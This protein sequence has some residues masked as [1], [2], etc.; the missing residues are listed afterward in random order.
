MRGTPPQ[1]IST[2]LGK[3]DHEVLAPRRLTVIGVPSLPVAAQKQAQ[4][5][6]PSFG[7]LGLAACA[8]MCFPG[9]SSVCSS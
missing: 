4:V 8:N 7:R 1:L 6:L 5:Q 2:A 3:L 9:L